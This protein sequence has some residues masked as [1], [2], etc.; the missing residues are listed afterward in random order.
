MAAINIKTL[1]RS[2]ITGGVAQLWRILSRFILT[3][4]IIDQIG[5]RGYGVWTLVFSVAAY[6]DMSNVSL[7]L[8]YTKFTAECVQRRKFEELGRIVGSGIALVTPIG[9]LG[10]VIAALWGESILSAINVPDDLLT[11]A[12]WALVVIIAMMLLRMTVGCRLEILAGLQRIDLT[13]RLY[14]I[15]SVIEFAASLPL[16]LMGYGLLG[17]A[18]GHAVGQIAIN[19][20]AYWMVR[21]R[22]P[23]VRISP[24]FASRDGLR[25]ILSV[26]GRFQVLSVVNTVVL[27]GVKLMLSWLMGVN[28][29]AIY[30]LAHKLIQLGRTASQAIIAPMMPAFASLRAGGDRRSEEQLFFNGSKANAF[31]AW[32]AFGFLALMAPTILLVWTGKLQPEAAW[33]LRALAIGEAVALLTAIVSSSLRAQGLVGLEFTQAMV[34]T[35][36]FLALIVVLGPLWQFEGLIYSRLIAQLLG[37]LWYLRAYFRFMKMSWRAYL[38]STRIPVLG[39]ILLSVGATLMV[40]R[41]LLPPL[42]PPGL[43]MRWQAVIEVLV[44]AVPFVGL[45]G[46][47][48]WRLYLIPSDRE[49]MVTLGRA[50]VDRL[51][52]RSNYVPPEIIIVSEAP[53]ADVAPLIAVADEVGRSE[54]MRLAQADQYLRSGANARVLLYFVGDDDEIERAYA[55]ISSHRP[56]LV[57]RLAFVGG[58]ADHPVFTESSVAHYPQVPTADQLRADWPAVAAAEE[59]NG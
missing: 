18:I 45:L 28:W 31:F 37:A 8:A 49:Q 55:W 46:V 26:G 52:G 9:I 11:D 7:G 48:A 47:G 10:L 43:S 1:G 29:V 5:M 40:A 34:N 41:Q 57:P 15:A 12:T 4:I 54:P 42:A 16:L 51:R 44:W 23:Q 35:G 24:F 32:T 25:K 36:L 13:F 19:I 58:G 59:S 33:A 6:I 14:V 56:D 39:L 30:E 21:S 3:P 2:S 53:A 50:I 22:L 17:L 20:A 27:Q 38:V